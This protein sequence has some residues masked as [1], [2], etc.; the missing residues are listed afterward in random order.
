MFVSAVRSAEIC[1]HDAEGDA[2]GVS[3][4]LLA[5]PCGLVAEPAVLLAGLE[6]HAARN[7]AKPAAAIASC[8]CRF[9]RTRRLP[10]ALSTGAV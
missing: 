5:E 4:G 3:D 10:A 8:Q 6:L 9:V 1:T 7:A 2:T